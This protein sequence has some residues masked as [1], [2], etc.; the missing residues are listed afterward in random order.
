MNITSLLP[1][2]KARLGISGTVRDEY[3]AAII[4]GV[5][6]ELEQQQGIRLL[7]D[8]PHHQMFVVDYVV[9]RYQSR[10]SIVA[11]PRH[12][13]YRLHCLIVSDGGTEQ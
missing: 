13:Q 4:K 9:W 6:T 5:I 8:S 1:L 2:V 11:M 7:P 3:L 10:D 12:I